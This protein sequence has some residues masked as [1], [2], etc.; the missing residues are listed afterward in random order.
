MAL[1]MD[2]GGIHEECLSS[3]Y[4]IFKELGFN[5]RR[6]AGS[7]PRHFLSLMQ[8]LKMIGTATLKS[9]GH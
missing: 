2:E 9:P 8:Q 5:I 6:K 3:H 4:D 7:H 1:L